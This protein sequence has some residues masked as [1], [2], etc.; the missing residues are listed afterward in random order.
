MA[1]NLMSSEIFQL[2][3][4][5]SLAGDQPKACEEIV[6]S[7]K[8]GKRNHVLLGVTGSGKTFTMA[9]V[10]ARLNVSSL[11]I[12]PNKTLAAQLYTE[13]KNLFPQNAVG[14]FISY[15][16]YYQPEAYIPSTDTY[17]SKDSSINDD[18]DKMRHE[19][20]RMLF[21][22][23]KVIIVASVS[24]IYGLGSPQNY[25][26]K[27]V[28]VEVG[29]KIS[30]NDFIKCLIE[31]QYFRSDHDFKRGSFR[32][33][34]DSVDL[35][36]AHNNDESIRIEF[37]QNTIESIMLIDALTSEV[38]KEVSTIT[39]YPNSHYVTE[40]KSLKTIINEIQKD[41]QKRLSKLK[42]EGN[43]QAYQKL[44]QRVMEDIEALE[45]LGFCPGI[46]NY[47]RYLDGRKS[48]EAPPC[49]LDYFPEDFLTIIDE[50]HITVPQIGAMYH[51]D[52]SR[53]KKPR[54]FWFSPSICNGQSP[55]ELSRVS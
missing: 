10:I 35:F 34:G 40:E 15:Y 4:S 43:L 7:F 30:R 39:L 27:I 18:I 17:I 1:L 54:G 53:K 55:S 50:S 33:R 20:T 21:E 14:Y 6:T 32:V 19:S 37:W 22:Q 36:P 31:I 8:K 44:E 2:K 41:L 26:K 52:R 42:E 46:E 25:A 47:S 13:L 45:Q 49:L 9:N 12:A 51:G 24:C 23:K 16:D 29:Q 38:K 3:S 48:G 5:F 11:I 28:P